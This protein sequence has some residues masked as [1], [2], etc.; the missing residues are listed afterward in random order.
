M[1]LVIITGCNSGD[2][3]NSQK[4]DS[5]PTAIIDTLEIDSIYGELDRLWWRGDKA[6]EIYQKFMKNNCIGLD[7]ILP[8]DPSRWILQEKLIGL[9]YVDTTKFFL[10]VFSKFPYGGGSSFKVKKVN[11][12][13]LLTVKTYVNARDGKASILSSHKYYLPESVLDDFYKKF[14]NVDFSK[15]RMH[16][17]I[18]GYSELCFEVILDGSYKRFNVKA[19][20]ETNNDMERLVS[21]VVKNVYQEGVHGI[22][23]GL[24]TIVIRDFNL[25]L[26]PEK[27]NPYFDF[28]ELER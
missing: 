11:G 9:G 1:G 18:S 20:D 23:L 4:S 5:T 26:K 16:E 27:A 2:Y 7:T 13:T 25:K 21:N 17:N 10:R 24:D 28:C 14:K 3:S 22:S 12:A 15:V 8:S 6:S 19:L